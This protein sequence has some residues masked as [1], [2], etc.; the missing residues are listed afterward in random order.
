MNYIFETARLKLREF[1]LRDASFIVGLMNSPGWLQFIGDR[2]IRNE[3]DAIAY[4][5]SGPIKSYADNGFGLW[6]V[7]CKDTGT[8][9]GMCGIL[10]RDNLANPDI[11]FALLSE[12]AGR[13]YGREVA[14]ATLSYAFETLELPAIAAITKP[15]NHKSIKLLEAIGLKF[16]TRIAGSNQGEHLLLYHIQK[17]A[18]NQK[19]RP[20][21]H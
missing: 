18:G 19:L 1:G 3:E 20:T 12:Y 14:E 9:V 7:E 2:N 13:G 6:L 4:L 17:F 16:Q 10:K 15:D 11:G 8:A 5:K 21:L